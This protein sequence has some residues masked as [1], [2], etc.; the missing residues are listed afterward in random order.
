MLQLPFFSAM[1][2][3][4]PTRRTSSVR[5]EI[6]VETKNKNNPKPRSGQHV[7]KATFRSENVMPPTYRVG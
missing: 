3:P 2:N 7:L 5:S 1:Q 6:F 4:P